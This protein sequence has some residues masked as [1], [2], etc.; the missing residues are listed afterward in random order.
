MR[1]NAGGDASRHAEGRDP[2]LVD[3]PALVEGTG[4]AEAQVP[5]GLGAATAK[6]MVLWGGTVSI[7]FSTVVLLAVVS[8]HL[9]H[10]GFSGLSTLFGLFFVAS[11][12]P[13]GFPLRAAALAVDG[14][15]PMR[16]T[17]KQTALCAAAGAAVS[18][19]IAYLLHL[20]VV[21]VLCVAAQVIVAIPLSMR[22]GLL[23]AAH[24]FNAMGANLFL[25]SGARIVLG[26]LLGLTWGLDGM[27]AGLAIATVIALI[28]VPGQAPAAVRTERQMTSLLDTWLALVLLGLFVQLDILLAPRVMHHPA[29]TRYDLAAV[30]TKGVYLV[31]LAVSTL[32][33]PYVRV[34][35]QRRTVLL[36][37]AATLGLGLAVSVV[38]VCMRGTIA[39]VLGQNVASAPLLLALGA[40]MSIAGATGIVINGGI[41]L[42]VTRPWP[43][44]VLGMLCIGGCEYFHPKSWQF[45]IVV[46]AS[47]LGTLLLTA[48][49]CLRW[50]PAVAAERRQNAPLARFGRWSYGNLTHL[51][52]TP[53][54][55]SRPIEAAYSSS[56]R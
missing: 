18:P 44:L 31:L 29:A 32:I 35:A 33:F 21:A 51:I 42:G 47:Q 53:I 26:V 5:G 16:T 7:G 39:A 24:R 15:P 34:H 54:Q 25:E 28:A 8:R 43:P 49:V 38:I 37:A 17:A 4:P 11:L 27:S 45:G 56:P 2:A 20:P 41:A 1:D 6:G 46:L 48:W 23:I 14:A 50:H 55:S 9:H 30:P 52:T 13:A 36:A 22:R 19:L 40:A 3:D 10:E 12:I